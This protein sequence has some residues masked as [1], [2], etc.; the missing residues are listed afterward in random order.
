[1]QSPTQ[2]VLN[3][4]LTEACNYRCQ[5]CY[6]AWKESACPRELIHDVEQTT[7][8]LRELYR[9]F[10]PTNHANPLASSLSDL[11]S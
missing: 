5:Y 4:H 2:L 11:N 1:M 3:W 7:A 9:F 10:H 8:L 6:A